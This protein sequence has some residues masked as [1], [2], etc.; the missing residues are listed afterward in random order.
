MIE[1]DDRPEE[2]FRQGFT[3]TCAA[4]GGSEGKQQVPLF[5]PCG[6]QAGPL[7]VVRV[8]GSEGRLG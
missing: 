7:N 5:P 1:I 8:V 6:G 2:E 3:G 4:A